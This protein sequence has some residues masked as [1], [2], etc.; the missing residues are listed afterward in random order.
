MHRVSATK[1]TIAKHQLPRIN[2]QES[3][4]KNQPKVICYRQGI[5]PGPV[6]S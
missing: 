4:A 5:E 2:C 1:S 6:S 3:T